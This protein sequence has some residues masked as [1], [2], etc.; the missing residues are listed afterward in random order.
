[1]LIECG[2]EYLGFPLVIPYHREDLSIGEA[3][4]VVA[5]LRGRA[6]F[7]LITYLDTAPA[8][9]DLC[10]QLDVSTVQ[11]HAATKVAE[12]KWIP[13]SEKHRLLPAAGSIPIKNRRSNDHP[14]RRA[15]C[16]TV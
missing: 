14:R 10:R 2:V 9:I 3:A 1:M 16:T 15:P 6:T 5:K 4:A 8:V 7:F 12:L 13:F 11:L